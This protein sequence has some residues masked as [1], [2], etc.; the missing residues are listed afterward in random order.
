MVRSFENFPPNAVENLPQKKFL[1]ILKRNTSYRQSNVTQPA[2]PSQSTVSPY[3]F[4][5]DLKYKN[6]MAMIR[7]H[8]QQKVRRNSQQIFYCLVIREKLRLKSASIREIQM[9]ESIS[10]ME[11]YRFENSNFELKKSL[12]HIC[13]IFLKNSQA[14]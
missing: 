13:S 5:I 7:H 10:F 3:P 14:S 6:N 4:L 8:V 1:D 2:S 9:Q 11:N 12:K